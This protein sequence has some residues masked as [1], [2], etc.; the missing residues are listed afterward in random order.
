VL[1]AAVAVRQR[2]L[3]PVHSADQLADVVSRDAD[4]NAQVT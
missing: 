4:L 1:A 3:S 2:D